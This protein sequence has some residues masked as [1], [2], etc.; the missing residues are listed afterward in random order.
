[1]VLD[2]FRVLMQ[3]VAQFPAAL[4]FDLADPFPGEGKVSADLFEGLWVGVE[5]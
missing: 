3:P 2:S 4:G 1:M 5:I